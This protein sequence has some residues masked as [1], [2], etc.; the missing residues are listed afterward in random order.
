MHCLPWAEKQPGPNRLPMRAVG[1][2]GD[3]PQHQ[4]AGVYQETAQAGPWPGGWPGG[5]VT[6][7][8]RKA[9]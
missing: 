9:A 3:L 5:S 6:K 7:L 4:G 1:W 8:F 2:A